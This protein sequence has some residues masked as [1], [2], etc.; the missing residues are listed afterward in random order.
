MSVAYELA[1]RRLP[2]FPIDELIE[3]VSFVNLQ[4]H[5]PSEYANRFLEDAEDEDVDQ[6]QT[7]FYEKLA[8]ER[9]LIVE[10]SGSAAHADWDRIMYL[11]ECL[12]NVT[13]GDIFDDEENNLIYKGEL[14][15]AEE[16]DFDQWWSK[17]LKL[18]E[19]GYRNPGRRYKW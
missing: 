2:P 9:I 4:T 15:S 14:E 3:S 7:E 16:T 5:L 10:F 18:F 11:M 6:E 12:A 17:K 1:C 19:E 13:D 8:A